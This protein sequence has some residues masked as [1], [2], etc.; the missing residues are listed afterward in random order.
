M[1]GP[2]DDC[3]CVCLQQRSLELPSDSTTQSLRGMRLQLLAKS[4]FEAQSRTRRL[5][6]DP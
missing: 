3:C 2:A 4:K 6:A 5:P 1:S